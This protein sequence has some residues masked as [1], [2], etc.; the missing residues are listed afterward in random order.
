MDGPA[1]LFLQADEVDRV[2]SSANSINLIKEDEFGRSF[3]NNRNS[4]WPKTDI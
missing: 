3:I 2:L 1:G 4:N